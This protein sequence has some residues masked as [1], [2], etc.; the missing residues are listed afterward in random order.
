MIT[1]S[2][3]NAASTLWARLGRSYLQHFLNLAGMRQTVLGPGGYWGLTQ[4]TAHDEMLLLRLL[5][6]SN[7][8]LS[9]GSRSYAL[10]LMS[11]VISSQRWGVP[12]G[13]PRTVTV[14]V[15]NG[16]LPRA[17]HGWRINS[18]GGFT[19]AQ[20]L[21]QHRGPVHGQPDHVLRDHY[22]RGH[23]PSHPPRPEPG[24][25]GRDPPVHAEPGLGDAGRADPGIV[26]DGPAVTD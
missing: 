20:G 25:D 12:A 3:N 1:K 6:T 9:S 23:R 21:V 22:R 24:D 18:I 8:V 7:A 14:H 13:A 17:T 4:V 2:D 19:S 15:K 5:L 11:Q 10:S 26:A 16:W